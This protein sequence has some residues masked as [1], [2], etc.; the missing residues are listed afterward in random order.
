MLSSLL[1]RNIFEKSWKGNNQYFITIISIVKR[2]L[3]NFRGIEKDR[4]L[5]SI[6]DIG[7]GIQ[8]SA[9][10]VAVMVCRSVEG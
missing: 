7:R 2:D 5:A 10:N 6:S 3:R 8:P 4:I 9:R 1:F